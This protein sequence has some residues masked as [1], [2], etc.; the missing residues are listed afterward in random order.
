MTDRLI[1][2]TCEK[3]L[4]SDASRQSLIRIRGIISKHLA[5]LSTS[6]TRRKGKGN[7][8]RITGPAVPKP[9]ARPYELTAN[10]RWW[11][12]IKDFDDA[13]ARMRSGVPSH[14]MSRRLMRD[15][16]ARSPLRMHNSL[17]CR[18]A[19]LNLLYI[20]TYYLVCRCQFTNIIVSLRNRMIDNCSFACLGFDRFLPLSH[21][22]PSRCCKIRH[23]SKKIRIY[24]QQEFY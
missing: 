16:W 10:C 20:H 8:L 5:T 22:F 11:A 1:A 7:F 18:D 17:R 9:Q 13:M 6:R 24:D 19:Q 2:L 12:H 21:L 14:V 15:E 4:I 3:C 23:V